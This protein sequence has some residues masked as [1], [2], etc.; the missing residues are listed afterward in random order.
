M[1]APSVIRYTLAGDA[2]TLH[3]SAGCLML[4]GRLCTK[5]QD[6]AVNR[7]FLCSRWMKCAA[8]YA[9]TNIAVPH[10]GHRFGVARIS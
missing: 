8:N 5:G 1:P 7:G 10:S 3:T 4:Y 6:C 9:D 2:G